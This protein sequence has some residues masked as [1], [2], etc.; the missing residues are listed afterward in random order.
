MDVSTVLSFVLFTF[1]VALVS[2]WKT[3]KKN[4]ETTTG[5]F[6]ASRKNNFW[7][8]GGALFLSNISANQF[9]GENES[10]YINNMS[11]IA[12]GVSSVAAMLLV[13]EF[14]LPVYF[15]TG[16]MTI[17]DF[18]GKR[19]DA[20]T[21]RLV[22]LVFLVSYIVNLLPAVLYGGAVAFTGMFDFLDFLNLTYWQNIWIVV[23]VIGLIGTLYSILGGLR[24]ITISDSV[25]SI[26]LLIIG[27]AFPYFGF[28]YLG[29]DSW[30][31]GLQLV[32]TTHKEHLDS[33]GGAGDEIPFGTIFTG[34]FII[35]LYYWGMEQYIVQQAMTAKNLSHSQKGM[36]LACVG[37]LL[38]PFLI[39]IPGI[40]GVHLYDNLSYTAA[41]FPL[42]VKDTLPAVMTGLT[43]AVVLGAAITTF[44]A[45]LNSSSTLFILNLYKPW[46]KLR[47]RK[48]TESMLVRNGK[49]FEIA[50]SLLAMCC[51]PFIMFVNTG[52]YTYLQQLT[53]MFCVPVFTIIFIGF[54]TRKVPPG[55]AKTGLVF[56]IVAY[57]ICNFILDIPLHYLHLLGI[58]FVL[59][60]VCML[61]SVRWF[62]EHHYRETIR[63]DVD[64]SPWK[65]RH[66]AA[67]TLLLGMVLVFAF[68]S[69]AGIA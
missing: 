7:V 42:V 54:V 5:L 20:S 25:L 14:F 58:L 8:V 1:L 51:A 33:I 12:W 35:N 40:I 13:A 38:C 53:G 50:I 46:M 11:V 27:V 18:L 31:E 49:R 67:I 61:L 24:A 2:W 44:N 36:A 68:F 66:W 47:N 32:L 63:K 15:R 57:L 48:V 55:A 41:V 30:T 28:R 10:I 29:N 59:T 60:S 65:Y 19:Y 52:F 4:T 17:P 6:F 39:N 22:S 62:P 16:A 34:M 23:W 21:K 26:G 56:F 37:K 43:A 69:A 3:R 45:G 9:I 64:I